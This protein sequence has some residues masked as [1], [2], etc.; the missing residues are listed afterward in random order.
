[1]RI[2]VVG[3]SHGDNK[4]LERIAQIE[5][6]A[7]VFLHAGDSQSQPEE[8]RPFL[9]IRGNCDFFIPNLQPNII[10]DTDYGKLYMQ[11]FP[12]SLPDMKR[13]REEGVRIF[14]HGHTHT[15]EDKKYDDFYYFSPGS[16]SR[17]R[18]DGPS[19]LVIETTSDSLT[20]EFKSI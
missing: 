19:Y 12:I 20:Y 4:T 10:I 11:H 8:I 13:L 9:A 15:K 7:N 3:D 2:I 6:K 1:M 18:D 14:I 17:P 16:C 5:Y